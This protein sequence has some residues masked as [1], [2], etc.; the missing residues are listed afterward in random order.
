MHLTHLS[1][2]DFRSYP[3]LDLQLAPGVTTFVGS[4]GQ[5]KTNLLEAVGYLATLSSHRVASDAPLVREGAA[6][7]ALRARIVRG[8]R[9]ALVEIEIIPGRANRARL[10]RAPLARPRDVLGLLVMVLFA[11]EDLALVRGDP[12]ERRRFLDDLLVARAPRL[13]GVLADYDKVLRQRSTL[14]RTAAAA[15]RGGRTSDLRTL[16]VWDAQLARYGSELVAARGALVEALRPRV[17]TAYSAVAGAPAGAPAASPVSGARDDVRTDRALTVIE[18]R[19]TVAAGASD[20]AVSGPGPGGPVPGEPVSTDRAALEAAMLTELARV[21]P[22]ELERG[23]T[24]VGP[25]RDELLLSINGRP[26]RGYA[27]HGESWSLALAL[28]LASF[29]LLRDDQ[30]EPVLLLDDVFAELD[31]NRR[32]RLAELVAPAEQVLVTAAVDADVPAA[33]AGVRFEVADGQV[34]HVVG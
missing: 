26:A 25:H 21:R 27:S 9:A 1:L 31:V 7:A 13:A 20:Q 30:R 22:R 5:G 17:E 11:P 24:L 14:L 28:K 6:S 33:L 4:N 18:Y 32:A 8:D 10:N 23:V 3:A 29:D 19:S 12:A 34:H 16:D 15:R 2:V